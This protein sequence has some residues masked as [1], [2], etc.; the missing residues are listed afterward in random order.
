M[1]KSFNTIIAAFAIISLLASC[2]SSS[3]NVRDAARQSLENP[4]QVSEV[5]DFSDQP[6]AIEVPAGP[7]TEIAFEETE[8]DFGSIVEGEKVSH[9]YKF[10][11]T[12]KDP[13]IIADARGTCG[14]TVPAWPREPIAPGESASITVEFDSK[15]KRGPKNQKVTITANTNPPQT[16]IYLKGDVLAPEGEEEPVNQ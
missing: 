2:Q 11:N 14:C 3:G 16:F 6:D 7:T 1:L 8:F 13:L 10:K 9:T 4:G 5:A 12:G 15:N